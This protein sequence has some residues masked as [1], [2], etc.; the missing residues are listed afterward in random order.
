MKKYFL[1][2]FN[3]DTALS[4]AA[5]DN[6]AT[7]SIASA[8]PVMLENKSASRRFFHSFG[9]LTLI[10]SLVAGGW[11]YYQHRPLTSAPPM[12]VKTTADYISNDQLEAQY[13]V[14]VTLIS[15]IA[16]GGI[17]DFRYKV[18]DPA[19]ADILFQDPANKPILTAMDSGH[20]LSPTQMSRHHRQMAAKRGAVPFM[21]FPNVNHVVKTGTPV[22]VSFGKI[23][24]EPITAQ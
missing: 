10:G 14:R 4:V 13:G 7:S 8:K 9:V 23:K 16:V 5:T 11:Y 21:F 12:A 1:S 2:G 20:T 3:N 6:L 22:S 19:R 17:V 18:T 24:V 15:V